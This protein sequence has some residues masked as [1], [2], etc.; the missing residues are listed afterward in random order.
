MRDH[1]RP[2]CT[3][4]PFASRN[5]I[6][7][8][9]AIVAWSLAATLGMLLLVGLAGSPAEAAPQARSAIAQSGD[10]GPTAGAP[11]EAT[12]ELLRRLLELLKKAEQESDDINGRVGGSVMT[13]GAFMDAVVES[14][15]LIDTM[16]DPAQAPSLAP[17]DT[18]ADDPSVQPTTLQGYADT[19]IDL[20]DAAY[21]E[22]LLGP[23]MDDYAIG[24][25]LKTI[26]RLLP[27][28][29]TSAGL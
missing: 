28:Y 14:Q 23:D 22:S 27:E 8:A 6:R 19:C 16:F 12:R 24:S 2:Q 25:H 11:T 1:D 3:V 26:E 21:Y 9:R 4:S 7:G 13:A 17:V 5:Q 20:A 18:G 15:G 29:I 10:I